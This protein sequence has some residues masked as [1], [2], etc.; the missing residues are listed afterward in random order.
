VRIAGIVTGRQRPGTASGVIFI[1]LED[2][3]G[4]TNVV[5]WE[6]LQQRYRE[7]LLKAKL[8]LVKGVVETDQAV[9]HVIAG[10]LIDCSRYLAEMELS[11]RDFH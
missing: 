11:S 10:K 7:A 1:T 2:Q 9:V 8:L 3:T 4:N 5:V 6:N